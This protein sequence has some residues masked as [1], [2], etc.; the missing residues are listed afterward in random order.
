MAGQGVVRSIIGRK[1]EPKQFTLPPDQFQQDQQLGGGKSS[2]L[3]VM[4]IAHGIDG[5]Q[6]L[7]ILKT[8]EGSDV[9]RVID[10][11]MLLKNSSD[12]QYLEV[13]RANMRSST[14]VMI[15]WSDATPR[16]MTHQ[17]ISCTIISTTIAIDI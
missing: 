10:H 13:K 6:N 2:R 14:N 1:G 5:S 7:L 17:R 15:Q 16:I 8:R 11:S 4:W 9:L 12:E 3:R